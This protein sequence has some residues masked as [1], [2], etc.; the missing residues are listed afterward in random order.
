MSNEPKLVAEIRTKLGTSES[1]RLRKQGSVPGNVYGHGKDPVAISVPD[2]DIMS[3]VQSGSH[4]VDLEIGSDCEKA[5]FRDIQW[6][7]F[8]TSI[9]HFDLIRVDPNERVTVEVAIELRGVAAGVLSGG[10]LDHQLHSLTID[11]PAIQIPDRLSVKV[12]D[13]EIGQA[14]HVS[15]LEVP[16]STNVQNSADA[17]VVRINAPT[18]IEEPEETLE[19]PA[20][21]ELV[22]KKEEEEQP[23]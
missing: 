9:L 22:G 12:S 7:T 4:V 14:V 2:E 8:S 23:E 17:I 18:E 1:R 13:L 6:D 15:D 10:V 21:P 20:E 19:G 11:C 5:I 16:E 3:L